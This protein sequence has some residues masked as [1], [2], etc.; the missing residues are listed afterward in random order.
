MYQYR[1]RWKVLE[2][3]W[4]LFGKRSGKQKKYFTRQRLRGCYAGLQVSLTDKKNLISGIHPPM[5]KERM[6]E[7]EGEKE[8]SKK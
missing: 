4:I 7:K 5:E 8:R 6:R 3:V 1:H 2:F